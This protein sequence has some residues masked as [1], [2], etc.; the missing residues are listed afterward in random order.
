MQFTKTQK[1]IISAVVIIVL[2]GIYIAFDRR[3]K[4]Q[5]NNIPSNVNQT[6]T[7]TAT[8]TDSSSK[9]S[10][11]GVTYKIEPVPTNG[12]KTVP[13]PIPD[14]DRPVTRSS[15]ANVSENDVLVATKKIKE[16]QTQLK[17]D[18]SNFLAW[19]DLA[20][21]QKMAGDYA[22]AVL[23]WKY[24]SKLA[25][26]DYISLGNLG[27][28]YAYFLK[29]NGQAEIYYKQAIS[30]GPTQVYLYMQ[31]A[32]IYRDIFK[33]LDKARAIIAQGLSKIPNDPS[34]LQFQ[35]SLK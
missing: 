8:T 5:T 11:Q 3:S 1:I 12:A 23:S 27:N 29:D 6:A 30:K 9:T 19:L 14:L 33:D 15:M 25:P 13:K 31:L 2:L 32:D 17:N 24:A 35:A 16:L 34:L 22:G 18:P 7:T 20:M 28:L 4:V 26:T 10:T 21:Y